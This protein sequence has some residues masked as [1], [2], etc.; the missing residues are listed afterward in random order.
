M[1]H[2]N[3]YVRKLFK[4]FFKAKDRLPFFL[5]ELIYEALQSV[6]VGTLTPEIAP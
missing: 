6:Y 3:K 1:Y 5:V 4:V 2:Y